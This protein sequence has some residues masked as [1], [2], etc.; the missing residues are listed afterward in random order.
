MRIISE[1]H[2][3]LVVETKGKAVPL[4]FWLILFIHAGLLYITNDWEKNPPWTMVKVLAGVYAV[5]AILAHGPL[6][7]TLRITFHG[8]R[9]EVIVERF[10][11]L[12]NKITRRY[13]FDDFTHY[14][15][16]PALDHGFCRICL[17][18]S[19]KK[20]HLFN[21]GK[22]DEF[23]RLRNIDSITRKEVKII[24]KKADI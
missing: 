20:V 17:K 24:H 15:L 19:N 13:S 4:G 5:L 1:T 12:K 3:A 7:D 6:R 14:E 23:E 10:L 8:A 16:S 2:R 21:I 18:R 22:N 11:P 9:H